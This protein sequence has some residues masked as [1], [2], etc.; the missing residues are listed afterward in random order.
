[1]A[2]LLLCGMQAG[3]QTTIC[4][5]PADTG[6]VARLDIHAPKG[7]NALLEKNRRNNKAEKTFEGYRIQIYAG[8]NRQKAQKIKSEFYKEFPKAKAYIVYQQP[9]FKIRV[10]NFRNKMEAQELYY[11]LKTA[12][13]SVLIVPTE[14]E[15]P[16]LPD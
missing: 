1:M 16:V 7:L 2:G 14:I 11:D 4:D 12:F 3:A 6:S 13:P 10:G 9:N 5:N 8:Q 15:Y